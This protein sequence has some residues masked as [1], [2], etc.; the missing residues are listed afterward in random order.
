VIYR[1]TLSRLEVA[2]LAGWERAD[3]RWVTIDDVR[4]VAGDGAARVA[5]ALVRKGVLVRLRPGLYLTRPFR[6]FSRPS[7]IPAPIALEALLHAEPHYLGGL[8][9]FTRNGLTEQQYLSR[10]DAF[11]ARPHRPTA[12]PRARVKFHVLP[13]DWLDVGVV[14]VVIDRVRLRM[15]GP[16]RTLV[17]IL[18][19]PAMAGGLTGAVGLFRR[20]LPQVSAGRLAEYASLVART[21]T[22]QRIGLLLD[23]AGAP[24]AMLRRLSAR[25][26]GTRSLISLEPGPRTGRVNTRW[27]VVEN[28]EGLDPPRSP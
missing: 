13:L 23:R 21:S 18:D 7:A 9:A 28:D 2:L 1:P 15:S 26:R 20:A 4:E 17:D 12:L 27:S 6:L 5:S 3:R 11:V 24:P 14:E 10:I 22:C 19:R 25:T 16:E 8:W